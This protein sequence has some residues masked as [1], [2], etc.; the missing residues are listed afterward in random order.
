MCKWE[1]F[2]KQ[3][4]KPPPLR[5]GDRTKHSDDTPSWLHASMTSLPLRV[6]QLSTSSL[7]QPDECSEWVVT[8]ATVMLS[9]P[10]PYILP[11]SPR[12]QWAQTHTQ[13]MHTPTH[14]HTYSQTLCQHV[15][16]HTYFIFHCV[17]FRSESLTQT[18]SETHTKTMHM[19][20][21]PCS[22]GHNYVIQRRERSP[23]GQKKKEEEEIQWRYNVITGENRKHTVL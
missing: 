22:F 15:D 19:P 7:W 6:W 8:L 3:F 13:T 14:T 9:W 17:F 16:M 2:G 4:T 10:S 11:D 18:L 12:W 21:R 5:E 23:M 1:S 20:T